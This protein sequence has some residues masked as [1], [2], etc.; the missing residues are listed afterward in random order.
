MRK[1]IVPL[2]IIALLV[3]IT[4][5]SSCSNKELLP[6]LGRWTGDFA[7]ESIRTGPNTATDLKRSTL[8][9]FMQIYASHKGFKIHLEGEQESFD[10]SGT[11]RLQGKRLVIRTQDIKIDDGGGVDARDPNRKFILPDDFRAAYNRPI[12]LDLIPTRHALEGLPMTVGELIGRHRFTKD[13]Y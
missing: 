11:W 2:L 4:A 10:V 6:Y 3:V 12:L 9:G 8:H 13:S 7:V 1:L 5:R